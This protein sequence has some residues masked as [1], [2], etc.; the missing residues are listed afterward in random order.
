MKLETRQQ[1]YPTRV[2]GSK[3]QVVYLTAEDGIL[4]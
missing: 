1:H 3:P 2:I 4:P